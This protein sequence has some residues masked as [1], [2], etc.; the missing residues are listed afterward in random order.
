MAFATVATLS[1]SQRPS[2]T[3]GATNAHP[4][5][6]R[7]GRHASTPATDV[8][9]DKRPVRRSRWVTS[10]PWSTHGGEYVPRPRRRHRCRHARPIASHATLRVSLCHR[11]RHAAMLLDGFAVPPLPSCSTLLDFYSNLLYSKYS[12]LPLFLLFHTCDISPL[13]ALRHP[14]LHALRHAP[15]SRP[16]C[17]SRSKS[18]TLDALRLRAGCGDAC[19]PKQAWPT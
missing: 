2:T 11:C 12:D 3:V 17:A 4:C 14:P 19:L 10:F 1:D 8:G 16:A 7:W 6:R 5:N 9:G 18:C 13:D 15:S